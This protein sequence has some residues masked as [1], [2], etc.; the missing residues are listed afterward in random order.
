MGLFHL[1]SKCACVTSKY[2]MEENKTLVLALNLAM[3]VDE[4]GH[5]QL[6]SLDQDKLEGS[7]W[8]K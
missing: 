2:R 5:A 4:R 7:K 1:F 3:S 8:R 6:S